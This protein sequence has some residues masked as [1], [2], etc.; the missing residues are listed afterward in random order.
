VNLDPK[1]QCRPDSR[2]TT[3]RR[4]CGHAKS[5]SRRTTGDARDR[6]SPRNS[7]H[8]SL[9]ASHV[10]RGQRVP[11]QA[12]SD[13]RH[14][15]NHPHAERPQPNGCR[16][17]P[18]FNA[19]L[20][21]WRAILALYALAEGGAD[22]PVPGSLIDASMTATSRC[23]APSRVTTDI[24]Q[25]ACRSRSGVSDAT[26]YPAVAVIENDPPLFPLPNPSASLN[27][28]SAS[29]TPPGRRSITPLSAEARMRLGRRTSSHTT[30]PVGSQPMSPSCPRC[31]HV[32]TTNELH[33]C[34]DGWLRASAQRLTIR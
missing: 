12:V 23:C 18:A 20:A 30:R 34:R 16:R 17:D 11:D 15:R 26:E 19:R 1:G 14:H 33:P 21:W 24:T 32:R 28:R 13:F 5:S 2:T 29:R 27:R 7:D 9:Q 3:I 4:L 25:G 31:C 6:N 22:P 10:E 8:S